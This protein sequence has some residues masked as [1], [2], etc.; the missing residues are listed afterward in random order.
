MRAH[1]HSVIKIE[2][3]TDLNLSADDS[4]LA[5]FQLNIFHQLKYLNFF[6]PK[7]THAHM[8]TQNAYRLVSLS[9]SIDAATA[10]AAIPI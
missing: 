8:Q 2:L 6:R 5:L 10:S 9:A 1:E 3:R 4:V 7:H